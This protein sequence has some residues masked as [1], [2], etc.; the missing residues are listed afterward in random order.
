MTSNKNHEGPT[1]IDA[2][3]RQVVAGSLAIIGAASTSLLAG[4][5]GDS[6]GD[7]GGYVTP[8]TLMWM[9]PSNGATN[10]GVDTRITLV[11]SESVTVG[12][13]AINVTGPS[14]AVTTTMTVS[15]ADVTLTPVNPLTP[16][17]KYTVTITSGVKSAANN[18]YAGSTESFSTTA[19]ALSLAAGALSD[20]SYYAY[21]W[22]SAP[23]QPWNVLQYLRRNGFRWLRMWVTTL[24]YPELRTTSEW[25]NLLWQDNYWACLEASG[26][27]LAAAAAL[28]F[29]LQAV[30][31]LSDQSAYAGKQPLAA[32]WAGLTSTELATAVQQS[33]AS[34]A[35]Y[36]QSLG[37]DI[38]VFEIGNEI[39]F[40][41]CGIELGTTAPVPPGIDWTT[42]PGWM[43]SNVWG[44]CA[45]LL[46]AAITGVK[47]VYPS[48]KIL[49][50]IAGFGYS[51]GN[52]LTS[53]FFQSMV[54]LG[55]PFDIAGLSY[56]Y[57]FSGGD[58]PQPY[59]AQADFLSALD[60]IAAV[61]KPIQIVEFSYPAAP[62]GITKTPSPAYPFTPAGQANFIQDLA[63]TVNGRVESLWYWGADYYLGWPDAAN[64]PELVS[65][66]LFSAYDTPRPAMAA[67]KQPPFA[68]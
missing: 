32:A 4:C 18:S 46:Q 56:P 13:N 16:G 3:R 8:L 51:P 67:F 1:A 41:I 10:A 61:G 29:R 40:G 19:Q 20:A 35:S 6:S 44:P 53:A 25:S 66:G 31:F 45:P 50:H 68:T 17:Q 43:Q 24:S 30:L 15:G 52:I 39:D 63:N 62:D 12:S 33:A 27:I 22:S 2:Q 38:E 49:L 37:L 21:R 5:G 42:D 60:S 57:M 9:A 48:A 7:G 34:T 28:G 26:S 36:Y 54:N 64:H 14:G 11:F 23:A 58:V 55:V 59:F 47:S 65:S